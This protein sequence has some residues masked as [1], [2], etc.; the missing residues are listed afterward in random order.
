MSGAYRKW[1]PR[2]AVFGGNG[3]AMLLRLPRRRAV[4]RDRLEDIGGGL[5]VTDPVSRPVALDLG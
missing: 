4:N 1:Q 5:G 3:D 2:T